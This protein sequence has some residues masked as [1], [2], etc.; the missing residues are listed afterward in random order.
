MYTNA[1]ITLYNCWYNPDTRKQ[2]YHRTQIRDI[3]WYTEQKTNVGDKG[4]VSADLYKL[5]I[6]DSAVVQDDRKYIEA[7]KYRGLAADEVSGYWTI[8][9]GDLFIKG[10]IYDEIEKLSDLTLKYTN[11]GRVNSFSDNR[12]GLNPHI[13]IGGAS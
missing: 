4:I 8:N 2:E 9:N 5:R 10:I 6:P 11:V 7:M 3:H 12:Q 1:D 13:R